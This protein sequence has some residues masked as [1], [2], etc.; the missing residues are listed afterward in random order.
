MVHLVTT[1]PPDRYSRWTCHLDTARMSEGG[2]AVSAPQARH[3]VGGLDVNPW[4][5]QL[6]MTSRDPA[7]ARSPL[8][9]VASTSMRP[10]TQRCGRCTTNRGFRPRGG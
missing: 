10:P 9:C 1:D 2:V 4:Q 6:W 7:S 3:I 5:T 8:M